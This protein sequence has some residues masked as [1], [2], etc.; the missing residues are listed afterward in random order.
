MRTCLLLFGLLAAASPAFAQS[1]PPAPT[2][3]ITSGGVGN[4]NLSGSYGGK[5]TGISVM[6]D[7]TDMGLGSSSMG[8]GSMGSSYGS[9]SLNAGSGISIDGSG[10]SD[11]MS[12]LPAAG[13]GTSR[14]VPNTQR[15]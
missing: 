15:Y 13:G 1:L 9:T 3:K 14:P 2:G 6:G 12:S 4:Y 8:N 11:G 10:F 7:T 5:N